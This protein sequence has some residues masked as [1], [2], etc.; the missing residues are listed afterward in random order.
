MPPQHLDELPDRHVVP[1][2]DQE[3]PEDLTLLAR[4]QAQLPVTGPGAHGAEHGEAK[5]RFLV[6]NWPHN[7]PASVLSWSPCADAGNGPSFSS[8][9]ADVTQL[10][11]LVVGC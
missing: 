9:P 10:A 2:P 7:C 3:Q 8:D 5:S 11:P 1:G 4:A 6:H